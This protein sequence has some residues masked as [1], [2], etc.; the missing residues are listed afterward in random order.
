M[1]PLEKQFEYPALYTTAGRLS[2]DSQ[3]IFLRLIRG[4][5]LALFIA[6]CLSMDWSKKPEFFAVCALV[7]VCSLSVL[8]ARTYLKPE[9]SWYRGRALAESIKTSCWRYCMRA[10]PFGDAA[11]LA[12]PKSEFRSHLLEILQ[13]NRFIGNRLPPD[14]AANE[15]IPISMDEVRLLTLD[16]RKKYYLNMRI[17]EQRNWYAIKAGKNN[18]ASRRWTAIGI[19]AY[20]IAIVLALSRIYWPCWSL[21]PIDAALV[22]A[23]GV[24]GWTQV[25]KFNELAASYILTAHEIGFTQGKIEDIS[26]E[27][28]FSEFVNDTEQAFSREHTQWVARQRVQ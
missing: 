3:T 6:A 19:C 18:A 2:D 10:Q 27:E 17:K 1:D 11:H 12:K 15:Q 9:Q 4:E 8:I 7:L 23:S 13:A 21:W 14:S 22:F 26:T 20:S 28:S 5:Y 25:K 16:E 24:I